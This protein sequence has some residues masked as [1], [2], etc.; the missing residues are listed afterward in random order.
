MKT[1]R[2][3]RVDELLKQELGLLMERD[4]APAQSALVTLTRVKTSPDLQQAEVYVSVMGSEAQ[5]QTVL[6]LLHDYRREFQSVIARHIKIK[7]TPILHFHLDSTIEK[8]GNVLA[9]M[10][11]LHLN[12]SAPAADPKADGAGDDEADPPAGK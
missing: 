9:L 7:Y 8:G 1:D 12:E 2:M 3:L 4:I 6:Q 5:K 10:E 11:Q